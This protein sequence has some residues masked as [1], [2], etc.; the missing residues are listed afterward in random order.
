MAKQK[1][2]LDKDNVNLMVAVCAVLISA[3]SF[4][5]TYIQSVAAERQVKAE[6]WPYLQIRSGNYDLEA[7][8]RNLYLKIENAGVGPAHLKSFQL[9]YKDT[10][11]GSINRVLPLCC[12]AEGETARDENGDLRPEFN[13]IIT[14][15]P[16]P[17]IVAAGDEILVYSMIRDEVN[18]DLWEKLNIGRQQ[19]R[20]E[21]C[22]CS[23]LDECFQTDFQSEPIPI[24]FC[25]VEKPAN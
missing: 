23:L 21:G 16:A 24:D 11:V 4:Y 9:Y 18:A 13:N 14:G 12:F 2:W 7:Q 15:N 5:A 22:Y 25:P 8:E 3:A 6:T 10:A 20:A 1:K 17:S 19:L